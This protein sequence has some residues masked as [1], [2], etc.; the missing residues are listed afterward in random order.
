M[1]IFFKLEIYFNAVEQGCQTYDPRDNLMPGGQN[2]AYGLIFGGPC[3]DFV[4]RF[5]CLVSELDLQKN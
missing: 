2:V 3:K 4:P 1:L 5:K